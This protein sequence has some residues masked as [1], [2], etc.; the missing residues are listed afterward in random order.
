MPETEDTTHSLRRQYQRVAIFDA[1]NSTKERRKW[2][3]EQ[4]A[5][6]NKESGIT[7]GVVFVESICNDRELLEENFHQ[8]ITTCPDFQNIPRKEALAD[9]QE[10]VK[11][12]ESRYEPMGDDDTQSYIQ[13]FNLSSK[14]LVNHVYGRL[15]KVVVP[16]LMG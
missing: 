12:Y 16:A 2:I 11:K 13:I 8:K 6:A 4:C 7:T 5:V 3:L 9:L 15:A 1:T 10:R 14:I